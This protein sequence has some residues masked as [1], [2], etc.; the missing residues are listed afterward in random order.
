MR[1]LQ[2]AEYSLR[3]FR[4]LRR[5]SQHT[6]ELFLLEL[7]KLKNGKSDEKELVGDSKISW[8]DFCK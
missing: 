2:E 1:L 8:K 7:K 4:N 6:P 5:V 3:F